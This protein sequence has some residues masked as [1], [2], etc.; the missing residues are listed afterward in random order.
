MSTIILSLQ[1]HNASVG[2]L[3][4]RC[5]IGSQ[6]AADIPLHHMPRHTVQRVQGSDR[7]FG[8]DR[9]DQV[10][11]ALLKRAIVIP[12]HI[13]QR[14]KQRH[15]Q[16]AHAGRIRPLQ[17]QQNVFVLCMPRAD[18]QP[19]E[20]RQKSVPGSCLAAFDFGYAAFTLSRRTSQTVLLSIADQLCSPNPKG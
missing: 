18:N 7:L 8:A 14:H 3:L 4:L 16:V 5:A 6:L 17:Q 11:A 19:V 1:R 2:F 10:D 15:I 9:P 12:C 13:G 20:Q